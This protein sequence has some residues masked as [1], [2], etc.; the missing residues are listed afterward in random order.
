MNYGI[1]LVR[2]HLPPAGGLIS[3]CITELKPR[4]E[5]TW[6]DS[7]NNVT[8]VALYDGCAGVPGKLLD[9]LQKAAHS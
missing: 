9:C 5:Q 7:C 4:T 2:L 6:L 1:R 8:T 3:K